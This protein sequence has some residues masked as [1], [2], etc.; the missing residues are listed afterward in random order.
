MYTIAIVKNIGGKKLWQITAIHQVFSSIFTISITFPMQMDF[1]LPVFS[2]KLPTVLIRQT[3][4][5]KVF[6]YIRYIRNLK[7][8][9]IFL[10]M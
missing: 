1:N 3:F 9:L 4:I 10:R 7:L 5:A 2:A 8:V 6:Y